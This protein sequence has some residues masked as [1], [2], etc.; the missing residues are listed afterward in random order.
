MSAFLGPIHHLMYGKVAF[1]NQLTDAA[2]RL[3]EA[4]QWA[5]GLAQRLE[6][7][8]GAPEQGAL[9]DLIDTANIHGWLSQRVLRAEERWD[10]AVRAIL[11][12]DAARLE[13][14]K[15]LVSALGS[16]R[17]LP[18][19][20]D[21]ETAYRHLDSLLL[22]GMPCDGGR[23]VMAQDAGELVWSYESGIHPLS[24]P[25]GSIVNPYAALRA[26]LLEG[27]LAQSGLHLQALNESTFRLTKE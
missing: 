18:P 3:A 13:A 16:E 7:D 25:A 6:R 19:D 15:T 22:D 26:A 27:V 14:L 20:S 23:R 10:A 2:L 11:E 24:A 12:E 8:F 1:Q 21:L 17:A 9:E 5:P 4:R